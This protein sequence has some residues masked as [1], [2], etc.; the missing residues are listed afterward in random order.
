[1]ATSGC[2]CRLGGQ[3]ELCHH[4]MLPALRSTGLDVTSLLTI[5]DDV[6]EALAAEEPVVGLESTI[7]SHGFPYPD[8]LRLALQVE[9]T[10]RAAGATPATI[11]L[12]DG[13]VVVGLGTAEIERFA[14]DR[15]AAKVSR[16]N[17]AATL[18]QGDL[19]AT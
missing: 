4:Q 6:R 11:G 17:L 13:R 10:V 5:R 7:I 16:R 15:S 2:E 18:A 12:M 14:Q 19:G 1:A 3:R 9:E 8:N